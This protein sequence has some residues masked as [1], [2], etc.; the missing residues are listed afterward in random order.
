MVGIEEFGGEIGEGL[1]VKLKLALEGSVRDSTTLTEECQDLI[2]HHIK[3]HSP[4]SL[5]HWSDISF[6]P[7]I[8]DVEDHLCGS[9]SYPHWHGHCLTREPAVFS[10]MPR[11]GAVTA[12][13]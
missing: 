5:V 9:T 13:A 7:D 10:R 4:P 1:V 6:P 2:E 12:H 8:Q 11:P 3:V